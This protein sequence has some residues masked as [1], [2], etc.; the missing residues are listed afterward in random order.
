MYKASRTVI[1]DDLIQVHPYMKG[2][3]LRN[4]LLKLAGVT[5]PQG[6]VPLDSRLSFMHRELARQSLERLFSWNFD[7]LIM[8]YGGCIEKDAK[9]CVVQ[10]FKWLM[11]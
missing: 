7:K 5:S 8:A 4:T 9:P 10:A 11:R 2:K 6:G 1:L 3:Q